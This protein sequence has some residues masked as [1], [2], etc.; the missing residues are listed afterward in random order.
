LEKADAQL[1]IKIAQHIT[2]GAFKGIEKL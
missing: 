1:Q 2:L